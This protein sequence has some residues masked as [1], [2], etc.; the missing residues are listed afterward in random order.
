MLP[1]GPHRGHELLV[2]QQDGLGCQHHLHPPLPEPEVLCALVRSGSSVYSRISSDSKRNQTRSFQAPAG[3]SWVAIGRS[4]LT[5]S[6]RYDV[7]LETGDGTQLRPRLTLTLDERVKPDPPE[8]GLVDV[9]PV[10]TVSWTNPGWPQHSSSSL[11]CDLRYRM[12]G[13]SS[14][15][16]VQEDDV[17]PSSYEFSSLE[18][19]TAYEVQARCIP[20]DRKG[21][22]SNWSP[23]LAFQTP[24]AAPVGLVDVW[25]AASHPGSGEPSLLLLWKPLD[26]RAARGVIRSYSITLRAGSD[27]TDSRLESPCCR[28]SLPSSTTHVW[29]S[30]NNHVGRT[31][32][33]NLSW[34]QQDLPAPEGIRAAA[35]QGQAL[36][37]TWE[38]GKDPREGE[39]P[40][41]LVE[42][43]K[44][45]SGSKAASLSWV[46]RPAGARSA[47]LTGDFRPQVPYQVRV[48][49]L[50]PQGFGAS[51]PVRAYAQEGVPS[52]GPRGLQD[53][54]VSKIASIISWEEIPLAQRNGHITH[55]TLYLETPTGSRQTYGPIA[56]TETSYNLSDLEPG[57]SY[58]LWM[59]GSTSAGEG[60]AS[61]I[62]L[63]HMP[64][65]SPCARRCCPDGAG[66]RSRIRSTA[67]SCCTRIP[68]TAWGLW[69]RA[70]PRRSPPSLSSISGSQQSTRIR[71]TQLCPSWSLSRPPCP[72]VRGPT[73][74]PGQRSWGQAA[75]RWRRSRE[76]RH[77]HPSFPAT[78]NIS[79]PPWRRCWDWPEGSGWGRT[80]SP[81]WLC[82]RRCRTQPGLPGFRDQRLGRRAFPCRGCPLRAQVGTLWL[83]GAGNG[84]WTLPL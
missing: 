47:L 53:R 35:E 28:A 54:S 64:G 21:V 40:E 66:R 58:Q 25:R 7:W 1:D 59:T 44:E 75:P 38:P 6:E 33:A 20:N 26:P 14:W 81:T 3:Q 13:A 52:A 22:W 72:T 70:K 84:T 76:S 61:S 80:S 42:W 37:V 31:Q 83:T 16:K 50:Y 32:P 43:V 49:G 55:Y 18:P 46:R 29:I 8:L 2:A 74:G 71:A 67:G 10:V 65:C 23:S 24:E 56:A 36:R 15:I 27:G 78:R 30:A 11:A 82:P 41:Y 68:T 34:E 73:T 5:H 62:H 48:Y 45:C 60:N 79:C 77:R 4:D 57:T 12:S 17:E 19:F 63:F 69:C 51:A 9:T 39:A